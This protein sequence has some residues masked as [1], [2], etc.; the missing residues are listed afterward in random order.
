MAVIIWFPATT[1]N[2]KDSL[3][4]SVCFSLWISS[5]VLMHL[6]F[7]Q[8]KGILFSDWWKEQLD[9]FRGTFGKWGLCW[10]TAAVSAQSGCSAQRATTLGRKSHAFPSLRKPA[11]QG[12]PSGSAS[13]KQ[14]KWCCLPEMITSA[15]RAGREMSSRIQVAFCARTFSWPLVS[16]MSP[17]TKPPTSQLQP[18]LY[19]C[20]DP[21][22]I[23]DLK[24]KGCL[25][26]AGENNEPTSL[27]LI[28][29]SATRL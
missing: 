2:V 14:P 19:G 18:W 15:R 7:P 4:Y 29:S 20:I 21:E 16:V 5:E 17:P 12:S 27:V 25:T 23:K 9:P 24:P 22:K 6:C 28:V 3:N 1:S 11:F 26:Q 8:V 13:G 10:S